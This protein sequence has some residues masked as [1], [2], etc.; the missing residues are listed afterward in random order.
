MMCETQ[1]TVEEPLSDFTRAVGSGLVAIVDLNRGRMSVTN[2]VERVLAYIAAEDKID[3]D[4]HL[5]IY[6][7]STGRWDGISTANGK[8]VGFYPLPVPRRTKTAQPSA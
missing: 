1:V 8:F 7:D 4:E 5:I 2:D 6:R 3:L